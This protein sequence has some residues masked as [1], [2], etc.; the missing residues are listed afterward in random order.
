MTN[1]ICHRLAHLRRH[2]T[3]AHGTSNDDKK[4]AELDEDMQ[5]VTKLVLSSSSDG[6]DSWMKQTCLA[7]I[8]TSYYAAYCSLQE[9]DHHISKVLF[10]KV[11]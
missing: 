1:Q 10:Q 9:I 8:R 5:K 11:D 6:V 3:T 4:I 2:N 7:I